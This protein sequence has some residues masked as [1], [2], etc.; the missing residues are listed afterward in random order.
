[1]KKTAIIGLLALAASFGTVTAQETKTDKNHE[2]IISDKTGWHKIGEATADF[3]TERQEV[4]VLGADRFASIRF[5]VS[6]APIDLVSL[7][8]FYES[9]DKQD[10]KVNTPVKAP[11]ESRTIDLNGGE[12][13]LKKIVFV[14]KTLPNHKDEKAHVEIWGLKTNADTKKA[15]M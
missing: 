4:I 2:L 13:N 1:M 11:G 5:K 12:R 7:E 15:G 14:Y 8:V 10:I 6:E 9:G 3:K